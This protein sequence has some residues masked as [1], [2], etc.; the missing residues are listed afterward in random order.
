[1]ET[2]RLLDHDPLAGITEYYHFDPADNS[3]GIETVQDVTAIVEA[4]KARQNADTGAWGE[5]T[6]FASTPMTVT[7]DLINKG[8]LDAGFRV[9]DRRRYAQWMNDPEN[10]HFRTKMG[11]I[12]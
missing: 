2:K 12:G 3:W 1:M 11:R 8:I 5:L 7:M 9:I 4:N 6:M 10:R